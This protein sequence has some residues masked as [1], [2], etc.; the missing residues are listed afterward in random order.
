MGGNGHA[1]LPKGHEVPRCQSTPIA[2][3]STIENFFECFARAGVNSPWKDKLSQTNTR[4]PLVNPRST[5]NVFIPSGDT[6]VLIPNYANMPEAQCLHE[7]INNLGMRDRFERVI[8]ARF[9]RILYPG[10]APVPGRQYFV[11][12]AFN[13][14]TIL[15]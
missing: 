3:E 9:Y 7:R 5:P 1:G 2:R 15:Q 12:S 11:S 13:P 10:S 8:G 6:G 14:F 4:I